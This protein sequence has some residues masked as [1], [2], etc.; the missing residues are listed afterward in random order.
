MCKQLYSLADLGPENF[1]GL[2]VMKEAMGTLQHHDAVTGT[3][4]QNVAFDYAKMLYKGFE[5]C[6][7]I[8][9]QAIK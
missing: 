5:E 9:Q 8:T 4:K 3:S 7:L 1:I 6:G 2:N